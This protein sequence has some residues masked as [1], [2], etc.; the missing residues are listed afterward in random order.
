MTTKAHEQTRYIADE[1]ESYYPSAVLSGIVGDPAHQAKGGYHISIEDQPSSSNYSVV[2]PDDKAPPGDWPRDLAAG[3]DMSMNPTDMKS[4]CDKLWNV[5]NDVSDPRRNYI[6]AFNGWFNNSDPAKRYDFVTQAISTTTSDHKWHVHL[7]ERR[8]Y[9]TDPVASEAIL[10]I[11][12]GESKAQ[13]LENLGEY[14][15]DM[16][17]KY[18]DK[19]DKVKALQLQ[20]LQLDPACLPNFGPDSGYGDETANALSRLVTGGDARVYGPDGWAEMQKLC[21][22]KNASNQSGGSIEWPLKGT[23]NYPGATFT[24]PAATFE[25]EITEQE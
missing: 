1:W 25:I 14:G 6:N 18:G 16:F 19:N 22:Q 5:W 20:L 7:E 8:K 13:Y 3:I 15:D 23:F 21:A 12:R 17:C 4:C 9:V 11:L 24:V 2:R 10:S